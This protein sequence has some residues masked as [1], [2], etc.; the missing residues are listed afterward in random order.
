MST[1][2]GA[3]ERKQSEIVDGGKDEDVDNAA[4]LDENVFKQ[5]TDLIETS[6]E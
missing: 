2:Q 6:A 5:N 3:E 1:E 4:N